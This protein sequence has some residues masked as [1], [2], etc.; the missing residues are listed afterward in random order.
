MYYILSS[1]TWMIISLKGEIKTLNENADLPVICLQHILN[2]AIYI[3][4]NFNS[5]FL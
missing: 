5:S 2:K 3:S 4:I 1:E